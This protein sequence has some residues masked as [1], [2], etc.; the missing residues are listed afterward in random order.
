MRDVYFEQLGWVSTPVYDR[1][2]LPTEQVI[3]G[4]VIIEEKAAVTVV[5]KSQK[6]MKD[7]FGNLIIEKE[8]K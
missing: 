5:Y 6:I 4:P 3:S 2:L 8:E 1:D 7:V